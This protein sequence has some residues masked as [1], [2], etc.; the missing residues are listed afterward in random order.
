M[1]KQMPTLPCSYSGLLTRAG[2][3]K[4]CDNREINLQTNTYARYVAL[5]EIEVKFSDRHQSK[6]YIQKSPSTHILYTQTRVAA[7]AGM[8]HYV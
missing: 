6:S 4:Y 7:S 5:Y 1:I 2:V 8:L 3:S